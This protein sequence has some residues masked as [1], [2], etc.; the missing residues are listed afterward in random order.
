MTTFPSEGFGPKPRDYQSICEVVGTVVPGVVVL[1]VGSVLQSRVM[2][3]RLSEMGYQVDVYK[4]KEGIVYVRQKPGALI[5][6]TQQE[7]AN[8]AQYAT[9]WGAVSVLSLSVLAAFAGYQ[10]AKQATKVFR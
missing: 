7:A 3:T 8:Y 9:N 5:T 6:A 1:A 2:G 10:L 4:V